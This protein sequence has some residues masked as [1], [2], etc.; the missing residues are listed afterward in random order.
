[1]K[2]FAHSGLKYNFLLKIY[3]LYFKRTEPYKYMNDE[4]SVLNQMI[5][6]RDEIIAQYEETIIEKSDKI[7]SKIS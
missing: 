4:K 7:V 1:M 3:G 6:N 5:Q 2:Y